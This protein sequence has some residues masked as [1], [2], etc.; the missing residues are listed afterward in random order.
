MWLWVTDWTA[1]DVDVDAATHVRQ[2]GSPRARILPR[3]CAVWRFPTDGPA[4]SQLLQAAATD[5]GPS[6]CQRDPDITNRSIGPA[7]WKKETWFAPARPGGA[8]PQDAIGELLLL[9]ATRRVLPGR[10]RGPRA[11]AGNS[12]NKIMSV[13][14]SGCLVLILTR[15]GSSSAGMSKG[16]RMTQ[17]V[18]FSKALSTCDSSSV[19]SEC[20]PWRRSAIQQKSRRVLDS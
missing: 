13:R 12:V 6:R 14:M 16:F 15:T 3:P 5:T 2:T 1:N 17:A 18:N 9:H 19:S 7:V 11:K 8:G 10:N 20:I 4:S